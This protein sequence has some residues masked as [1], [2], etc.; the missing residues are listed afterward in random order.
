MPSLAPSPRRG[1]AKRFLKRSPRKRNSIDKTTGAPSLLRMIL[2]RGTKCAAVIKSDLPSPFSAFA[3]FSLSLSFLPLINCR[4]ILAL[5]SG[6]SRSG[7]SLPG[8]FSHLFLPDRITLISLLF[9]SRDYAFLFFRSSNR[10]TPRV[11]SSL[12]RSSCSIILDRLFF[13]FFSLPFFLFAL[14]VRAR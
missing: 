3:C 11:I 8:L 9:S 6:E 1:I 5:R 4:S 13:V 14:C 10:V 7:N 2:A 12:F